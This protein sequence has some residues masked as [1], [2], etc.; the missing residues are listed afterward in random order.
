MRANTA[1]IHAHPSF[2][3]FPAANNMGQWAKITFPS[4]PA[5]HAFAKAHARTPNE[6]WNARDSNW[7]GLATQSREDFDR[8]GIATYIRDLVISS[9]GKMP[10]K[11]S[12]LANPHA[13][14]TGGY[15][16]TPS[17]LAGLPLSARTRKRAKLPPKNIKLAF[18]VSAGISAERMS[19]LTAKITRAI[20]EYTIAG[21]AVDLRVAYCGCAEQSSLGAKGIC[22][23]T[24]VNSSDVA[25][26]ALSISPA[27]YRTICGPLQTAFSESTSDGIYP[28]GNC[29][30]PG[31]LWI[32]GS[33]EAAIKAA[34]QTIKELQIA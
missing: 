18:F 15:W 16:D 25:A 7:L 12:R 3:L 27:M 20:W 19:A 28:P 14:V 8:T 31:Y 4:I 6:Q 26:I 11:L 29:P 13:A 17:V 21:G 33:M 22:I 5:T 1:A 32:G 23:E 34:E 24:H 9:E 30:L 2:T 10:H